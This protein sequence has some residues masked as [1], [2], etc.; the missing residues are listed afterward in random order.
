VT[1]FEIKTKVNTLV[2]QGK[3]IE[4]I[5]FIRTELN[6]SLLEAKELVDTA[7]NE[8]R[9]S[10]RYHP[11]AT[12][13]FNS[14]VVLLFIFSLLGVLFITVAGYLY[15]KDYQNTSAS[16]SVAGIVTKLNYESNNTAPVI[17]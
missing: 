7:E 11:P 5:K 17:E 13:P 6:L 2:Q 9:I 4:A 8:L 12:T 15:W 3:K 16:I 1:D 14:T 10:G